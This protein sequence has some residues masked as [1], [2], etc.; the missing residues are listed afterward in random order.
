MEIIFE[1]EI[2]T[3]VTQIIEKY[4]P[5]K[6]IL[7]GSVARGEYGLDSDADFL[8]VKN[9]T[10]FYGADRIRELSRIIERNIPVDFLIYRPE[11]FKNRLEMGDPFLKAIL[12]EGKVLYG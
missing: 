4:K 5:E 7:F 12:K 6:I 11:E 8:I 3:I 1:K 9:D 2:E 10:P